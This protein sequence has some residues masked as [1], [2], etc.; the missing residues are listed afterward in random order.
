MD[1]ATYL[2]RRGLTERTRENHVQNLARLRRTLAL[3]TAATALAAVQRYADDCRDRIASQCLSVSK[4]RNDLATLRHYGNWQVAQ[5]H[6][7]ENPLATLRLGLGHKW[8]PRPMP[9]E[10]VHALFKAVDQAPEPRRTRDRAIMRLLLDGLRSKEVIGLEETGIEISVTDQTLVLHVLGKG[11]K[12]G[13]VPLD[14]DAA[15]AL[16]DYLVGPGPGTAVE[17]MARWQPRKQ[18][19]F[20]GLQRRYLNRMFAA[21][22][23]QADLPPYQAADG[24]YRA[25]GPHSLRHTCATELLERGVDVRTVQEILRHSTIGVTQMYT[26]VRRSLKATAMRQLAGLST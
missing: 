22:R 5:G 12:P 25:Y 11:G 15:A 10:H 9:L 14:P 17:R 2:R 8:R 20:P 4:L 7:P 3:D 13:V 24:R 23:I 21:Y 19:V 6:W 18:P 26:E 1:F 16:A